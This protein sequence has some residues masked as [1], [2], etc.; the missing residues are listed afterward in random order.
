MLRRYY[1]LLVIVLLLQVLD[2]CPVTSPASDTLSAPT[3][4][5]LWDSA[6]ALASRSIGSL[7]YFR[8]FTS[9]YPLGSHMDVRDR[10]DL[11]TASP[12]LIVLQFLGGPEKD[13]DPVGPP[14]KSCAE[15][16]DE[17]PARPA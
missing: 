1:G 9:A 8:R 3:A 17:R 7:W 13:S 6:A 16:E 14:S 11:S 4:E 5:W 2:Q 12:V 10:R 15:M